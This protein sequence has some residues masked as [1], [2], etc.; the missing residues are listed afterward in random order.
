M[1]IGSCKWGFCHC[2]GTGEG[3]CKLIGEC[4]GTTMGA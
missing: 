4:T 3:G 1:F 2:R